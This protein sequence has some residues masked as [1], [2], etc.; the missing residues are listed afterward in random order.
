MTTPGLFVVAT[1]TGVGKTHVTSALIHL[2]GSEDRRVGAFKPIATGADRGSGDLLG[3]DGR[4]LSAAL[5]M[6]GF[7]PP[8]ERVV[9]LLFTAP[10]APPASARLEGRRIEYAELLGRTL[11]A[12]NWW[13][14]RSD[15]LLLE[16]IGGL[17]CPIAEDATLVRLAED[18]D[19]PLL[20]IARRGLGTLNHTLCTVE[21]ALRRGVRI[22]GIVLNESER[23]DADRSVE[24]NRHEL[25]RLL[26]GIGILA[27]LEYNPDINAALEA[28]KSHDW[29]GMARPPR[30]EVGW[31]PRA[32]RP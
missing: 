19:L 13:A 10:L 20:I 11:E 28:L 9:P 15:L 27:E 8:P 24:S 23:N 17:H 31:S 14:E 21:V 29:A 1:D 3:D 26:P 16:G 22:A 7:A 5:A 25:A 12:W 6:G 30:G 18:L 32:S 2:L 4:A